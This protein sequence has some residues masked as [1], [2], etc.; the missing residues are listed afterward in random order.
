MKPIKP[1]PTCPEEEAYLKYIDEHRNYVYTAFLR[2]GKTICLALSLVHGEYD[3]LRRH[4]S[5]HDISKY[6]TDEFNGYRQYFYAKEGEEKNKALFDKAWQHHYTNNPHHWE[7][8]LEMPGHAD[9]MPKLNVAEMLLDWI[10]MSMKF[11]NSPITWY[12]QNKDRMI[13]HKKTRDNVEQVLSVLS[14]ETQYPFRIRRKARPRH[15]KNE[16]N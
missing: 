7:Y 10:A 12:N 4:V 5:R 9:E 14:T 8:Y 16:H 2:F 13:L 1:T 15:I 3:I 6:G 11:K